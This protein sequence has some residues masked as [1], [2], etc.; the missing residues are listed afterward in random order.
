M[1]R[2]GK[3][4]IVIPSGVKV[5]VSGQTFTAEGPKGKFSLAINEAISIEVNGNEVLLNR[6]DEEKFSRSIHGTMRAQVQNVVTGVATGW[7]KTLEIIGVG[8]RAEQKG[9][10]LNLLLGF[11]HHVYVNAPTGIDFKVEGTNKIIISGIDRQ[12]V[13][14]V[15]SNIRKYRKPE[16]Y[17]GKG[18]KYE[19]EYIRRKQGKRTG[20]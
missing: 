6:P 7:S 13:G 12:L 8:Y 15:A 3:A 5:S 17:K 19:G 18:I 2:I 10:D 16:P 9:R 1:S 11:S 14:Q 20:K 4:P